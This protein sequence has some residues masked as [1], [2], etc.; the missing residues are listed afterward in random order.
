MFDKKALQ[1]GAIDGL[2]SS[3]EKR[4]R[5]L[6]LGL[7]VAKNAYILPLF[8][9][10]GGLEIIAFAT[11]ILA[12]STWLFYHCA[13]RKMGTILL[14]SALIGTPISIANEWTTLSVNL[15]MSPLLIWHMLV[16][17]GICIWWWVVSFRMRKM[18]CVLRHRYCMAHDEGYRQAITDLNSATT[19]EELASTF[20]TI[21][22]SSPGFLSRGVNKFYKQKKK[23]IKG[24]YIDLGLSPF[25]DDPSLNSGLN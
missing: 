3:K 17:T 24:T 16:G 7:T 6:W 19:T 9:F 14:T 18:N 1:Q 11:L 4:T 20:R 21:A 23:R 10:L 5:R 22:R 25:D 8:W 12:F 13:Y 2:L 15:T